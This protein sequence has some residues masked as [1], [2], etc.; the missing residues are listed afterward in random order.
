MLFIAEVRSQSSGGNLLK[1][2]NWIL[3]TFLL[4]FSLSWGVY[5]WFGIVM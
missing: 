3:F 1:K 2:K 4:L 5:Y